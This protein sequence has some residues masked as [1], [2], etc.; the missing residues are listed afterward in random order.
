MRCWRRGAGGLRPKAPRRQ[1]QSG[2]VHLCRRASG[3]IEVRGWG[4]ADIKVLEPGLRARK[5]YAPFE[6]WARSLFLLCRLFFSDPSTSLWPAGIFIAYIESADSSLQTLS[7]NSKL[8]KYIT[9]RDFHQDIC[10]DP[11]PCTT[12]SQ[13]C[14]TAN[15]TLNVMRALS[16]HS[17]LLS[18]CPSSQS[19][20]DVEFNLLTLF[21]KLWLRLHCYNIHI[22]QVRKVF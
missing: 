20:A 22:F 10:T 12:R 4:L 7:L 6:N 18:S 11:F 19:N 14:F 5:P 15:G 2:H 17:Q 3:W 21:F 8:L 13:H 1:P 16:S 9:S